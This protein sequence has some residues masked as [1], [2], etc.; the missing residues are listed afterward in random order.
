MSIEKAR[1]DFLKSMT[2]L[3]RHLTEMCTELR[4]E[5]YSQNLLK[6]LRASYKLARMQQKLVRLMELRHAIEHSDAS[7]E[8][9]IAVLAEAAVFAKSFKGDYFVLSTA[10]AYSTEIAL[11]A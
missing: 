11:T 7:T 9:R 1:T 5:T 8:E 2:G 3:R 10:H 4:T 6:R